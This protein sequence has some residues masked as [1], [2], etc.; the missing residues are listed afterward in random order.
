[1]AL[2]LFSTEQHEKF[3]RS[4]RVRHDHRHRRR[5][6]ARGDLHDDGR[7]GGGRKSLAAIGCLRYHQPEKPVR[8]DEIPDVVGNVA[9]LEGDLPVVD[10]PAQLLGRAVEKR[11]FLGAQLAGGACQQLGEIGV[12][13]QQIGLPADGA[14]VQRLAFGLRHGG[15]HAAD[16]VEHRLADIALAKRQ[17]SGHGRNFSGGIT[18]STGPACWHVR[19]LSAKPHASGR[20][21]LC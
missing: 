4:Q 2:L 20:R 14:G 6:P 10:Q 17:F 21:Y 3:A 18:A 12:A 19:R 16:P 1:M 15:Q 5:G 9:M 13:A 8:L 7:V 11:L